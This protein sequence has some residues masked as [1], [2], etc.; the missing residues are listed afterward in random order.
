VQLYPIYH[1]AAALYTPAMLEMLRSDFARLPGLLAGGAATEPV[2]APQPVA[3]AA[4]A[5]PMAEP[6]EAQ[7]TF[8]F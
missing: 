2:P 7:L 4:P 3:Y 8:Q 5:E 1:P 6:Q